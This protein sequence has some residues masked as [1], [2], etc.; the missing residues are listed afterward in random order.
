MTP[1]PLH[2]WGGGGSL[3]RFLTDFCN[4]IEARDFVNSA[5]WDYSRSCVPFY[6]GEAHGE[7]SLE[8]TARE[9]GY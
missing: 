3:S 2:V 8:A 6:F 1:Q 7:S 4:F 5:S 9:H